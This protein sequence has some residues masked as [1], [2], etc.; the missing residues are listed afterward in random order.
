MNQETVTETPRVYT[1]KEEA[2]IERHR[3]INTDHNWWECVYENVKEELDEIG[4]RVDEMRFSGFWS[5]GDGACF[6]G[7][8]SDW[9]KFCEQV[10]TFVKAFPF[11]SEYAKDQNSSYS[12]KHSG[13]YYH[14]YC[15]DHDYSS[16]L[17]YD[18]DNFANHE[19]LTAP[20]VQ[21]RFALWTKAFAEE[22]GVAD[23]LR[24]F[25]RDKMRDLYKRLEQ[26]YDYLTS[27][28]VVWES[29]EANDLDKQDML[30]DDEEDEDADD[31]SDRRTDGDDHAETPD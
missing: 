2:L 31:A 27:D 29:I 19:D 26:E 28:D 6:E 15:T 4:F 9:A 14:E 30:D 8:M 18:L 7:T 12:I 22:G 20:E 13:H 10:P 23:W 21:M 3:D 17:E 24:D 25:F 11:L 16:E 5:Q 1:K